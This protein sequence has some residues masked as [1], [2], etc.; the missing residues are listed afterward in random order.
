MIP[1]DIDFLSISTLAF[2]GILGCFQG[3]WG[4]R[5]ASVASG[6]SGIRNF[7]EA[8]VLRGGEGSEETFSRE[9]NR[10][11][12]QVQQSFGVILAVDTQPETDHGGNSFRLSILEGVVGNHAE[13]GDGLIRDECHQSTN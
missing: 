13:D 10:C 5:E 9:E 2:R 11:T 1:K 8:A 4:F 6:T 7:E 12:L 3:H